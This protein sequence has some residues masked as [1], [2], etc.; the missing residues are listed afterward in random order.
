MQ[1]SAEAVSEF[2]GWIPNI[3][4]EVTSRRY[5]AEHFGASCPYTGEDGKT[6]IVRRCENID[7]MLMYDPEAHEVCCTYPDCDVI[8]RFMDESGLCRLLITKVRTKLDDRA[9]IDIACACWNLLK[10]EIDNSSGTICE[11][12]AM[13]DVFVPGTNPYHTVLDG[14]IRGL[15]NITDSRNNIGGGASSL[16]RFGK[17]SKEEAVLRSNAVYFESFVRIY[18]DRLGCRV[19]NSTQRPRTCASRSSRSRQAITAAGIAPPPPL[20][21]S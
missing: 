5:I 21:C 1:G 8:V 2:I 19:W 16:F 20:R 9:S 11:C 7:V 15:E 10:A 13:N 18:G 4:G 17:E 6:V 3:G 14:F 12:R